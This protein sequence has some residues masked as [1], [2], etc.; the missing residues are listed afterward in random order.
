M[1]FA[2]QCE[3]VQGRGFQRGAYLCVCRDGFYFPDPRA[4]VL[5]FQ[6]WAIEEFYADVNSSVGDLDQFDCLRCAEG[7]ETCVDDAPCLYSYVMALRVVLLILTVVIIALVV[8]LF[9][10]IAVFKSSRV[11]DCVMYMCNVYV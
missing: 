1:S 2:L 11:S 7:C 3:P 8:S 4:D 6:G 9:F 5:A 10:I